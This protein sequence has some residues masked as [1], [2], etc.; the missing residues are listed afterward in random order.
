MTPYRYQGR[1]VMAEQWL[2]QAM[3]GAVI[4]DQ[5]WGKVA[6]VQTDLGNQWMMEGDWLVR[7]GASQRVVSPA[8]FGMWYSSL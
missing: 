5:K 4:M 2:G 1:Q 7:D 6:Q 3:A 8:L